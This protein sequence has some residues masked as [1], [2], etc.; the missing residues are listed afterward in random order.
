MQ[1][2]NIQSNFKPGSTAPDNT[3]FDELNAAL[4]KDVRVIRSVIMR[5]DQIIKT[6]FVDKSVAKSSRAPRENEVSAPDN[7]RSFFRQ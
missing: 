7:D 3:T 5:G 2:L 6:E 1:I 4:L